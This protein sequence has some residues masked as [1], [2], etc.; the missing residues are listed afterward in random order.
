MRIK[1]RMSL[2]I[3]IWIVS[4]ALCIG[5]TVGWFMLIDLDSLTDMQKALY[6]HLPTSALTIAMMYTTTRIQIRLLSKPIYK[7]PH[8]TNKRMS[9]DGADKNI[10]RILGLAKIKPKQIIPLFKEAATLENVLFPNKF[11]HKLKEY[12]TV[13]TNSDII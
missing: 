2:A 6:A 11:W 3:L 8:I 7:K 12:T 13:D 9:G 5:M 1:L 4:V 10:I